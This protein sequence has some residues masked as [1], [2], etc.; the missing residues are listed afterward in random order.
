MRRNFQR[1]LDML[2]E[3]LQKENRRPSLLLHGC[4]APCSSYVLEYLNSFFEITLFYY[5]PNIY[6]ASEYC[7]R[8]EEQRMLL[9]RLNIPILEGPYEPDAYDQAVQGLEGEPEG[10]ARCRKCFALR[11]EAA[12]AKAAEL[13]YDFFATTLSISPH[14]NAQLLGEL[15]ESIGHRYG[16]QHLPSDFKKKEGYKRS[17]QLSA[18]YGLYRQNYCGCLHSMK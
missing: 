1:E 14:K 8:L 11:L 10:G 7:R 15:G 2:L 13:S 18:E 6:P 3:Q 17:I 5:N 16:V 9:S 4:C 12:A